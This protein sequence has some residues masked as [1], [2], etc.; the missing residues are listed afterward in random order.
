MEW[1][2]TTGK[3]IEEATEQALDRLGVDVDEVDIEVLEEPKNGLFGK[4]RG[5]ARIRA[6]VKPAEVRPKVDRRRSRDRKAPRSGEA[7]VSADTDNSRQD[8]SGSG[9]RSAGGR[10]RSGGRSQDR[11]PPREER[12]GDPVDPALVGEAAVSFMEGLTAAFGF[13]ATVELQREDT[14]LEVTVNGS[15]LGLM[16]GHGGRTLVAIQDL[17][18]VAAQRRLGDHDTHLRVDI[19]K[20]RER[21][22]ASLEA[23]AKQIAE[24]VKES[25]RAVAVDPMSSADRKVL[26]DVLAEIEGVSSR[27]EGED[28]DRRVLVSPE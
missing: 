4:T 13:E 5:E 28:P 25:G 3:T 12:S 2:E 23:F 11:R 21:R 9:D 24:R 27:S 14:D 1:V 19:A 26:H 20:Y 18:R 22:R 8:K 10:G 17:V 7:K 16:V 15:E 6:R